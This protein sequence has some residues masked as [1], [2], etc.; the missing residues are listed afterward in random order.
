MN[1]QQPTAANK[2]KF[3]KFPLGLLSIGYPRCLFVI[4]VYSAIQDNRQ[5]ETDTP[6]SNSRLIEIIHFLTQEPYNSEKTDKM[7]QAYREADTLVRTWISHY[8]TGKFSESKESKGLD[9]VAR[10]PEKMLY[11]DWQGKKY[12]ETE[13]IVRFCAAVSSTLG[14]DKAFQRIIKQHLYLRMYGYRSE[15]VFKRECKLTRLSDPIDERI[16][17]NGLNTGI[18]ERIDFIEPEW[19]MTAKTL[20]QLER[21]RE[22]AAATGLF[23][24]YTPIANV[25]AGR[26]TYYST[27]LKTEELISRVYSFKRKRIMRKHEVTQCELSQQDITERIANSQ[28]QLSKLTP[29]DLT[30]KL[31]T[32]GEHIRLTQEDYDRLLR[33]SSMTKPDVDK[34]AYLA[35]AK[36]YEKGFK[37]QLTSEECFKKV[38]VAIL[39]LSMDS[40]DDDSD[41]ESLPRSDFS[42][43]I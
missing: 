35:N 27:R 24:F 16:H 25:R 23:H 21:V 15:E 30:P 5:S 11:H 34:A 4:R 42:E 40:D 31:V 39:E 36:L 18:D 33:T 6:L 28:R 26:E 10:L 13:P 19:P 43:T 22:K 1:S 2:K 8:K 3:I 38:M 29:N 12:W 20:K 9:A 7:I 17:F 14:T 37:W 32:F 41:D